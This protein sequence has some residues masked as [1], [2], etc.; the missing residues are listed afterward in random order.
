MNA[1]EMQY[2]YK[3]KLNKIDSQKYR[4]LKVPEIDWKLNEAQELLIKMILEPRLKSQVGFEMNQRTIDDVR[5]IVIDQKPADY[6]TSLSYDSTSYITSLPT[7]YW[8][9]AKV[10]I[11]AS[12]GSCTGVLM[13]DSQEIQHDDKSEYSVFNKSSFEWRVSNY[14]FNSQGLRNF[15]DATFSIDNIGFEYIKRPRA[16]YNA[17]D[18]VGGVYNGLDGQIYVGIQNCELPEEIHREIVDLAVFVTAGDLNLSSYQI[19]QNKVALNNKG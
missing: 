6:I 15:T 17:G 7:D 10:N 1:K 16:I 19:K 9:L 13:Y 18:Y 2:D 3:Q 11:I 14:R 8:F 5:T 12:K 4:N